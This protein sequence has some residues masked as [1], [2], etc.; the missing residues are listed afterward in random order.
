M[1]SRLSLW[2]R[3]SRLSSLSSS[4]RAAGSRVS[5]SFGDHLDTARTV[6]TDIGRPWCW[7]VFYSRL[8]Y[9]TVCSHRCTFGSLVFHDGVSS[10]SSSHPSAI[11]DAA[12]H[13]AADHALDVMYEEFERMLEESDLDDADIEMSQGVLTLKLGS[14]GTYVINKQAPNKQLW[15]SSPVRY[16]WLL[17]RQTQTMRP[18]RR[19]GR[20]SHSHARAYTR[21]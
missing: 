12:Y 8:I 13:E 7:R 15:V 9:S 19:A 11:D 1:T 2:S 6:P 17:R 14:L 4:Q 5:S 10:L 3:L 16:G 18:P 20:P 21:T